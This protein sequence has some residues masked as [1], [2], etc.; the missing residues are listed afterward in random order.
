MFQYD[1]WWNINRKYMLARTSRLWSVCYYHLISLLLISVYIF[2]WTQKTKPKLLSFD[3][4]H[5]V[6]LP[7]TH[8]VHTWSDNILRRDIAPNNAFPQTFAWCDEILLNHLRSKS[9]QTCITKSWF[10]KKPLIWF[11]YNKNVIWILT[12]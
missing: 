7:Q 6:S 5:V 2:Y 11:L 12:I 9:P 4:K 10:K 3:L 8:P 1:I